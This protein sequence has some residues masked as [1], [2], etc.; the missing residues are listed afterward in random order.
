MANKKITQDQIFQINELY[1]EKGTYAAVARELNMSPATVKKYV[2]PNYT[3][4]SEIQ[5]QRMSVDRIRE[6]ENF[7]LSS[8]EIN[9]PD[10]LKLTIEEVSDM[11][12]FW[13]AISL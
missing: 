6:I 12:K 3:P 10:I 8:E 5:D 1:A 11:K 9:N 13:E 7:I 4:A 2:N